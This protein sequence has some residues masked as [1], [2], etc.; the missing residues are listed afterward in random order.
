M[1]ALPSIVARQK[2]AKPAS[3]S[4][5]ACQRDATP[6]CAPTQQEDAKSV[7]PT[8]AARQRDATP[9]LLTID[10]SRKDITSPAPSLQTRVTLI[11]YLSFYL[12]IISN[13][14]FQFSLVSVSFQSVFASFG[15]VFII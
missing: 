7:L 10:A 2:D 9:S 1:P 12:I 4:T 14:C 15:L 13:F 5:A 6:Q 8:T 11:L 3:P